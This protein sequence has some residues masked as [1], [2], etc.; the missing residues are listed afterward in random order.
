MALPGLSFARASQFAPASDFPSPADEES[1]RIE[2]EDLNHSRLSRERA[3]WDVSAVDAQAHRLRAL[4]WHH[5]ACTEC[6]S[7]EQ[8]YRS[9]AQGG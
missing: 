6:L 4:R 1:D 2:D 7:S 9:R 5:M 8:S 3:C